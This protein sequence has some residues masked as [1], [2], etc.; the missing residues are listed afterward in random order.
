MFNPG[1]FYMLASVVLFA[2][3]VVVHFHTAHLSLPLSSSITVLAVVLPIAAFLNA[4]IYPNLL[5]NSHACALAPR[6][7]SALERLAPVLLQGL[8]AVVTSVLATL[9]FEGLVPSPALDYLVDYEWGRLYDARDAQ[10]I[11]LIQDTYRCC[12]LRAVDDRA[13]PFDD[14]PRACADV[15]GRVASC[16]APWKSA[17]Q[18]TSAVD[19]GVVLV[20]GLMQIIGLLL[21]RERTKWWTALRT[22]DW[23]QPYCDDTASQSLLIPDEEHE[24][25]GNPDPPPQAQGYG[26]LQERQ[27]TPT[28]RP[29]EEGN[30]P[31]SR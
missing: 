12:G 6:D 14:G 17:M 30:P 20:V 16:E 27:P 7:H 22:Q 21:M 10:S 2:V 13:Y 5:R 26:A 15:Y 1:V 8:Q 3:A 24:A 11:R 4:Y 29:V 18:I 9:L 31:R 28:V 23:K 19:F 25:D